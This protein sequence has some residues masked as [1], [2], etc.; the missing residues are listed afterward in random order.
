MKSYAFALS[1]MAAGLLCAQSTTTP[2]AGHRMRGNPDQMLENRLGRQ[3]GLSA[4]QQN[5]LHTALLESH[6]TT[7]GLGDQMKTLHTQLITAVKNG[8]TGQIDAI[9]MQMETI[10]SQQTAAQAKAMS[11]VYAT[12]SADQKTKAGENLEMLMGRGMGPGWGGR[13]LGRGVGPGPGQ[14]QIQQ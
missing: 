9:S 6:A 3:L 12:L 1:F 10:H 11:K 7:Q 8:D 5:T 14:P 13:G 4:A 2:P